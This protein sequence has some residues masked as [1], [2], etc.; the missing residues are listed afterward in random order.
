MFPKAAWE[1]SHKRDVKSF[2]GTLVGLG[3]HCGYELRL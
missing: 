2:E 3:V 1:V